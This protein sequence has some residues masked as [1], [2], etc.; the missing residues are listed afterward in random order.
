MT[1]IESNV[2][3]VAVERMTAEELLRELEGLAPP[4]ERPE[5][6][7]DAPSATRAE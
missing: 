7:S 4:E 6:G 5:E 2:T 3:E 1:T